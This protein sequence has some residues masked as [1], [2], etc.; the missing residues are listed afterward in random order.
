MGIWL[1]EQEVLVGYRFGYGGALTLVFEKHW[2]EA[3]IYVEK[4]FGSAREWLTGTAKPLI[5]IEKCPFN[6]CDIEATNLKK[7]AIVDYLRRLALIYSSNRKLHNF[8]KCNAAKVGNLKGIMNQAVLTKEMQCEDR[9]IQNYW[10]L[11]IS[12]P[13]TVTP[14]HTKLV[15]R[16]NYAGS[17]KV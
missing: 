4:D 15:R 8:L 14:I 1:K 11:R 12:R 3:P 5:R 7:E 10:E 9:R 2:D 17:K 16:D 13:R 6:F